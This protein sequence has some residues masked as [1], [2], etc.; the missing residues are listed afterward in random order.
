MSEAATAS[1]NASSS[2]FD[3]KHAKTALT[4]SSTT[5]R[6]AQLRA[7]DEKIAHKCEHRF[8]S[9]PSSKWSSGVVS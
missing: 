1:A 3:L 2:D 8:P 5:A 7:I 4:L 6:I 9:V